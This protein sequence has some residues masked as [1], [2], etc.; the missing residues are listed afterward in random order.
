MTNHIMA[1][2]DEGTGPVINILSD[3]AACIFLDLWLTVEAYFNNYFEISGFTGLC[4]MFDEMEKT[5]V[6]HGYEE[7]YL[8]GKIQLAGIDNYTHFPFL[9]PIY[10]KEPRAQFIQEQILKAIRNYE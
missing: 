7:D 1:N 6:I 4:E 2:Y 10:Q 9:W 5:G 8:A 3:D